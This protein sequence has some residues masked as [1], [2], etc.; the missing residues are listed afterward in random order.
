[1]ARKSRVWRLAVIG[2]A[3][4]F[5]VPATAA[6][7]LSGEWVGSYVCHQGMT[8]L[9]LTIEPDGAL[10][11]GIFAFGPTKDNKAVPHGSYELV[12]TESEG[13]FH[14]EPGSWIEQP[15][16]YASVALDGAVSDDMTMLAGDVAFED[17]TRFATERRTPMP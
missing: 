10:W 9:T 2:L 16:G 5:V 13:G 1:M 6:D 15:E 8:A 3:A 11:S 12:I 7:I 4:G 17:C 14:M